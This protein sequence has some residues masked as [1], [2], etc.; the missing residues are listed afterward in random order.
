[1]MIPATW[2]LRWVCGHTKNDRAHCPI[3]ITTCTNRLETQFN[4]DQ[5]DKFSSIN[6]MMR[7][8]LSDS[9]GVCKEPTPIFYLFFIYFLFI[10]YLFFPCLGPVAPIAYGRA[11][12][13]TKYTMFKESLPVLVFEIRS[14]PVCRV[15]TSR[16]DT[17]KPGFDS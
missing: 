6:K 3:A 9:I 12:Y 8:S 4:A 7:P 16:L 2:I 10:F 13:G 15:D 1:M 14:K 11:S 5:H 17:C